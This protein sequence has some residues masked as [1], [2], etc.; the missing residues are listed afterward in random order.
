LDVGPAVDAWIPDAPPDP[1]I[2]GLE[3]KLDVLRAQ[4][5][6]CREGRDPGEEGIATWSRLE[7]QSQRIAALEALVADL[8]QQLAAA[9]AVRATVQA[10]R[11]PHEAGVPADCTDDARA[12]QEIV[13]C[14]R[15]LRNLGQALIE[16]TTREAYTAARLTEMETRLSQAASRLEQDRA[17]AVAKRE[18]DRAA[19]ERDRAAYEEDRTAFARDRAAYETRIAQLQGMRAALL[20]STSWRISWPLRLVGGWWKRLA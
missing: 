6:A 5:A 8:H 20:S 1:V 15:T 2:R 18:Q 19:Y 17:E 7:V 13:A 16:M 12:R 11:P 4:L 3:R 10:H 9:S 14:H